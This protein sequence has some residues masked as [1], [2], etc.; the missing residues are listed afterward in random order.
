[1]TWDEVQGHWREYKGRVKER[2]GKLTDDDLEVIQGRRDRLVGVIQQKYGQAKEMVEREVSEWA[3]R[4]KVNTS[5][6]PRDT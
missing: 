3:G 2:W 5:S 4:L 6:V 1:M